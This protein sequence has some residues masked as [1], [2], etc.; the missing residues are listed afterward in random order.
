[1]VDFAPAKTKSCCP[2]AMAGAPLNAQDL[3]SSD[4][5]PILPP[6]GNL[7][8]ADSKLTILTS[9]LPGGTFIMGTDDADCSPE[10]GVGPAI[11]ISV[12]PFKLGVC[13]I[14]NAEFAA[15]IDATDYKTDAEKQGNSLVFYD[16]LPPDFLTRAV[17]DAPWWRQVDGASWSTPSGV[18]SNIKDRENHPVVHV[19]WNDARHFCDWA[20]GRLPS[21]AEWEFAA[22]GGEADQDFSW[23]DDLA[24]DGKYQSN[25]WRGQFPNRETLD[26]DLTSTVA[27]NAFEPNQFGLWNM[28][29]N[30]WE[31]CDN[32]FVPHIPFEHMSDLPDQ[33]MKA[34]RGGSWL[35]HE[36]YCARYKVWSRTGSPSGATTGHMGFRI[37]F[38]P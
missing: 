29:G 32:S 8:S 5:A 17:R 7:Q 12:E 9:N 18:H 14:S 21:E 20:G 13:S 35:C 23:G 26:E 28:T 4:D 36:S 22:R 16:Q 34:I 3:R 24:S 19:S 33:E 11:E 38:D 6:M 31:W 15:F 10:D 27:I 30:V 25:V 37:A 2:P 1:M